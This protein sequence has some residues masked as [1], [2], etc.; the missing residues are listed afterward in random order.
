M[1]LFVQIKILII[2]FVYGI[3]IS[4][5]LKLQY[6]YFFESKLWYKSLLTVFFVFDIVLIYFY[7]LKAINNG[8]FHIYFLISIISGYILGKKLLVWHIFC[9]EKKVH[10][11]FID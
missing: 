1:D 10:I 8:M 3:I 5:I 11:D 9:K 7:I 6:K 2:S 4:Y